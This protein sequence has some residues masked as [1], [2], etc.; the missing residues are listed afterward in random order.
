[1]AIDELDEA[2]AL[3]RQGRLKDAERLYKASLKRR[4]KRADGWFLLGVVQSQREDPAKAVSNFRQAIQLQPDHA[5]A[6]N[7][8]GLALMSLNRFDQSIASFRKAI[9]IKSD[10]FEAHNNLG[11]ALKETG[12]TT[13]AV[14]SFSRSIEIEPN[15]ADTFFNLGLS[16][17]EL[18]RPEDAVA[19][20]RRAAELNPIDAEALSNLGVTLFSLNRIEEAILAYRQALSVAPNFAEAHYNL[21]NALSAQGNLEAALASYRAAIKINP[22]YTAAQ[23]NLAITLLELRRYKETVAAGR[24][25]LELESGYRGVLGHIAFA[26]KAMCDWAGA[27]ATVAS[28]QKHIA[29]GGFIDPFVAVATGLSPATQL[30]CANNLLKTSIGRSPPLPAPQLETAGK[31]RIA[32]ISPDFRDHPVANAIVHLL[33]LHDRNKFEIIGVSLA[34]GD[35]SPARR[36]IEQSVD[37]MIDVTRKTDADAARE[38]REAGVHISVDL[39]GHTRHARPGIFSRRSAPVQ[40]NYLGYPGS[41]GGDF[42]DY[43]LADSTVLPFDQQPHF[44]ERIVHIPGSFM[45]SDTTRAISALAPSR[46]E[47]GLPDEGFVFC[48][49]NPGYKF[50]AAVFNIWMRILQS[51]TG[52]ILWISRQPEDVRSA[53]KQEAADRGIDPARLIFAERIDKI[54]DHLAR[55]RLADLFLDTLPYNAHST[56]CDAIWAGLPVLTCKGDTFA[57]R[58]AA[59]LLEAAGLPEL[60]TQNAN[61]Y[62]QLAVKLATEPMILQSCRERLAR[63]RLECAL[64]DADTHRRHIEAAFTAMWDN[65]KSGGQPKSFT[66]SP[67]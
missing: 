55:L 3:H 29:D 17:V 7:H 56:A 16:Y 33:E 63:S 28:I 9:S 64:F 50:S 31:L 40:V 37:R 67:S 32:Y 41:I 48:C 35:G 5:Q 59:S 53:L 6:H 12:E 54:E 26:Q 13:K 46:R 27:E 43:I 1:M 61:D 4:P 39:G 10:F 49:F 47:S 51:I 65:Y 30:A 42:V 57:G 8:L 38:L 15:C 22:A 44:S 60:I 11:R 20:F 66:V 21:A 24:A 58:V 62:E 2:L 36:R 34:P 25:A 18:S 14:E 19:A 23:S 52:S 45:P